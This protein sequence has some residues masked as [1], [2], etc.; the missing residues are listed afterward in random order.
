VIRKDDK[1]IKIQLVR[2][3]KGSADITK[4][5]FSHEIRKVK[6]AQK[7]F[8]ALGIDYDVIKGDE[9][10][11]FIKKKRDNLDYDLSKDLLKAAEDKTEY[12]E[13]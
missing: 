8:T 1:G 7:H 2:E 4:L 5:R 3:T 9:P 6:V 11:W 12:G 10:T 13:N